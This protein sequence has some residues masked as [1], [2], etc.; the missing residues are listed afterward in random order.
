MWSRHEAIQAFEQNVLPTLDVSALVG[1][2]LVCYPKSCHADS[3]AKKA[4]N[5]S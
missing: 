4:N 5:L 3:L 2:A 1:K